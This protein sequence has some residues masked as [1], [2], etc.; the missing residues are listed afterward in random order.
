MGVVPAPPESYGLQGVMELL[1]EYET[2]PIT[3]VIGQSSEQSPF[4]SGIINLNKVEY[5]RF[6]NANTVDLARRADEQVVGKDLGFGIAGLPVSL[7][8][9]EKM[10]LIT[11]V[12]VGR[13][14]FGE[15]AEAV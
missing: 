14:I 5:Q 13:I 12:T 11:V 4:A 6:D 8:L 10:D 9:G 7:P 2:F 1:V 3:G 15:I